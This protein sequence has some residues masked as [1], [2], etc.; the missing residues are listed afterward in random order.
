MTAK[1]IN[2]A[3]WFMRATQAIFALLCLSAPLTAQETSGWFRLLD[4]NKDG[5]VTRDEVPE[6]QRPLF[7]RIDANRD[8]VVTR[9]EDQKFASRGP[10]KSAP[11]AVHISDAIHA[12]LDLPYAANKNPRQ[13]LDLYLPKHPK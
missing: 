13:Q 8:G 12:K 2:M 9:E 3:H 10:G 7:D 6:K 1:G 11:T 4:R 5:K